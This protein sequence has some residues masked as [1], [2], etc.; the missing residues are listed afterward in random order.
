MKRTPYR[1]LGTLAAF[2]LFAAAA[3]TAAAQP[4]VP[5]PP[6]PGHPPSVPPRTVVT[7]GG[8]YER[9]IAAASNVSVSLCVVTGK[10]RVNGWD[11]E[12]V[13]IFIK[14]GSRPGFKVMEKGRS[15]KPVWV[16]AVSQEPAAADRPAQECLWGDEIQ[17]DLPAG[18]AI[19]VKGQETTTVIDTLRKARVRNIAGDVALRNITGGASASTYEGGIM[20]E[21][22]SGPVEIDSATGNIVVAGAGPGDPGDTFKAR[23][24]SGTISIQNL[25][26]RQMDVT[27]I[28][29]TVVFSGDMRPAGMYNISTSNG[30]I[31]LLMP[32]GASGKLSATYG[33]GSMNSEL[34]LK[35]LTENISPGSVKTV[36]WSFGEGGDT[37][38]RLTTSMGNISIR[39]Q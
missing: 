24:S 32:A 3:I 13:R 15:G 8:T 20:V 25:E 38:I 19:D 9:A 37:T 31:R 1:P 34:P 30:S 22:V 27:S 11:R 29:G 14:D 33:P 10:L 21:N 16:M 35:L 17:I 4:R 23:T 6:A 7:D 26:H 5:F 18:G 39:R 36:V 2:V 28:S 12:E